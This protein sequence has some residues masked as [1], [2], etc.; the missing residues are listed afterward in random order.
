[1]K[2]G[3]TARRSGMVGIEGWERK[4]A[5]EWRKDMVGSSGW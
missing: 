1:M 5:S 4:C 2:L 3:G